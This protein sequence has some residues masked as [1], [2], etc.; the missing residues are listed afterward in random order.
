M[1]TAASIINKINGAIKKVGPMARTTYKRTT[2][3]S[4][5][6][7]LIG[8]EGTVTNADTKFSPQPVYHQLGHR[9]AMVLST[10]ALQLVADDYKFIFPIAAVSFEDRRD[11]EDPNTYLLLL[12]Q[13]GF[14]SLRILYINTDMYQGRDVD[15]VIFA[16]SMGTDIGSIKG[17]ANG[18]AIVSGT[19]TTV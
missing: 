1:P 8:I 16:R 5:G 3:R 13:N 6:D 18:L 4:G 11:F 17:S 15:V 12:D 10:P 9:Q 7:E 2:T 14:E 19:L